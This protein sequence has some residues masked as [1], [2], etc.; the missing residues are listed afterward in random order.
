MFEMR[1]KFE[2]E[3]RRAYRKEHESDETFPLDGSDYARLVREHQYLEKHHHI[4]AEPYDDFLARMHA[5]GSALLSPVRGLIQKALYHWFSFVPKEKYEFP[6]APEV[7]TREELVQKRIDSLNEHLVELEDTENEWL[8]HKAY[9]AN[10]P[11][12]MEVA[13]SEE[14]T[15]PTFGVAAVIDPANEDPHGIAE[16]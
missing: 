4:N 7:P 16:P 1:E 14:T 13:E 2:E 10:D 6:T 8:T 5:R 11:S 15:F 9:A 3:K 12:L